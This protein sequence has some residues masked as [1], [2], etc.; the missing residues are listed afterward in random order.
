M[1]SRI[2]TLLCATPWLSLAPFAQAECKAEAS[3]LTQ[4]NPDFSQPNNASECEFYQ[5]SWQVCLH[6]LQD[7]AATGQPR[8]LGFPSADDLFDSA[9]P[10]APPKPALSRMLMMEST[11]AMPNLKVG[12]IRRLGFGLRVRKFATIGELEQAESDGV[13]VDQNG[14]AI[15]YALHI[16]P[17][18]KSHIR[19]TLKLS[20]ASELAD[21]ATSHPMAKFPEGCIEVKTSWRVKQSG[22]S[23]AGY[24]AIDGS[25]PRLVK[26]EG[27]KGVAVG[28]GLPPVNERMLL[29]G[30]HVVFTTV[31]HSEFIWATFEHKDNAPD[32]RSNEAGKPI[33]PVSDDTRY[34]LYRQGTATKDCNQ[35][36]ALKDAEFT[37]EAKQT[38]KPVTQV[39]RV[40]KNGGE[41]KPDDEI[42]PL[43]ASVHGL[44]KEDSPLRH[45]D[46]IGA[47][48]L[49]NGDA[50]FKVNQRYGFID[51]TSDAPLAG[52]VK[53]SNATMETFTQDSMHCFS[54]HHTKEQPVSGA[55]PFP[56]SLLG[57]SHVLT[58]A[59]LK[60]SKPK[61]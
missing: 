56:A 13:V 7:D 16:N 54:C 60:N 33:D 27:G 53:L 9:P 5:R 24:I 46:F 55:Q 50:D 35:L 49:K 30:I 47:M 31:G 17:A 18:F 42:N 3:W 15:Y 26:G 28:S 41:P 23:E 57:V 21:L 58:E 25:L 1:N 2:L 59:Y 61:P 19:D 52:E 39:A 20:N 36:F 37:D 4:Q 43:N 10:S 6:L 8:F 22:E 40:F 29:V 34:A 48:W 45:Y 51:G 11:R 12:K 38:L 32:Q 44:L 14:R